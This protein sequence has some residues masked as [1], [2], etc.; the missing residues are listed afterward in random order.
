MHLTRLSFL[1]LVWVLAPACGQSL[2]EIASPATGSR[3][4][5]WLDTWPND[6]R[7]TDST[8]PDAP[9]SSVL[10][11]GVDRSSDTEVQDTL[12][13]DAARDV[14]DTARRDAAVDT[15][16][17]TD[18]RD[19]PTSDTRDASTT[20]QRDAPTTDAADA[21]PQDGGDTNFSDD[22]DSSDL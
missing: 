8:N 5:T 22:T 3:D 11:A 4:A 20:D 16:V 10:D 12:A 19:A 15:A 18:L 9:D 13:A 7:P 17:V 6:G 2:V 14:L 21:G 1:A